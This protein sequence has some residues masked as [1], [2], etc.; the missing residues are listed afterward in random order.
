M[1]RLLGLLL[2]RRAGCLQAAGTAHLSA[3]RGC[4]RRLVSIDGCGWKRRRLAAGCVART[5]TRLDSRAD[6][7]GLAAAS[8][9]R[10]LGLAPRCPPAALPPTTASSRTTTTARHDVPVS[11][12]GLVQSYNSTR[13]G[14]CRAGRAAAAGT[15]HLATGKTKSWTGPGRLRA[16]T[17]QILKGRDSAGALAVLFFLSF[18]IFFFCCEASRAPRPRVRVRVRR[19]EIPD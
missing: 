18:S 7:T 19:G 13:G 6:V 12:R 5:R 1:S 9:A 16:R 11:Q 4:A 14:T 15:V 3:W 17:L 2:L 8:D 10:S